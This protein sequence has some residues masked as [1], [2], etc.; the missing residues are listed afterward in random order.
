VAP[1]LAVY[2]Y[3]NTTPARR[4]RPDILNRGGLRSP[5][6]WPPRQDVGQD[7]GPQETAHL[8]DQDDLK[9]AAGEGSIFGY[10]KG[11]P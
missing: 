5:V 10:L 4:L 8:L 9:L 6:Q 7:I 1:G 3:G 2:L 11:S